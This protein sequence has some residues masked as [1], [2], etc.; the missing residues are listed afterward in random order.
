LREW[1]PLTSEESMK[2]SRFTEEQMVAILREADKVLRQNLGL[3]KGVVAEEL[4]ER[5]HLLY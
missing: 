2:K 4:H 3:R 1:L 5:R